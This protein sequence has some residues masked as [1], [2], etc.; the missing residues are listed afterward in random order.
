MT[1]IL[2]ADDLG[3]DGMAML[4]D[5][6]DVTVKTGMNE[7]ALRAMLPGFET[8]VVRSATTVTEKSLELADS[9]A[10]IGRAGIGIDNIDVDACTARGI[11]VMNTPEAAA[12][13]TGEHA[14]SLLMSLARNVPAADA[15]IRAGKWE[16]G[17]FTG[18]ELQG[19][20]LGVVGLGQIGRVIA[21]KAAGIGM[22]IGAYDPFV[23]QASAPD[24]IRMMELE[25]LLAAAGE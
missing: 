4:R 13:T 11:A 23:P 16:K 2:V 19:K 3:E 24:G 20:Q 21:G 7:D 12:V 22:T 14:L 1:K 25:E 15:S 9:L 17:K 10:L 6:G 18:V 8:L 5:V